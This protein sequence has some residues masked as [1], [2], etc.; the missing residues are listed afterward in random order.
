MANLCN[1]LRQLKPKVIP[2]TSKLESHVTCFC[3]LFL[4]PNHGCIRY[5][6][7]CEF[8][9]FHS[10]SLKMFWQNSCDIV[11]KGATIPCSNYK[12]KL[13]LTPSMLQTCGN[14]FIPQ[15]DNCGI[16]WPDYNILSSAPYAISPNTPQTS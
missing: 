3:L 6:S 8:L 9:H 10:D 5:S 15:L 7:H 11:E 12:K 1:N 16:K 13:A 4:A 2:S 14:Y